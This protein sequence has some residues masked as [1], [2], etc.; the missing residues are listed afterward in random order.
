MGQGLS[1]SGETFV[2]IGSRNV[3]D[4]IDLNRLAEVR[5]W[6][7]P[8]INS[9]SNVKGW[10][11]QKVVN[12]IT[13]TVQ[14]FDMFDNPWGPPNRIPDGLHPLYWLENKNVPGKLH[15]IKQLRDEVKLAKSYGRHLVVFTRENTKIGSVLYK[16]AMQGNLTIVKVIPWHS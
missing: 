7:L 1:E 8:P 16:A 14:N 3:D 5:S 6:E 4:L 10:W 9:N 12:H 2:T 11:G 13:G 15:Y